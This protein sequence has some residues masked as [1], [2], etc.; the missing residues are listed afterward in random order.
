MSQ[1]PI[2]TRSFSIWMNMPSPYQADFFRA[3]AR[4]PEAN[5]HVIF[6]QPLDPMRKELGWVIDGAGFSSSSLP[7]TGRFL[8]ALRWAWRA[9]DHVHVING[10]WAVPEFLFATVILMLLGTPVYFHAE[11]PDSRGRRGGVRRFVRD[12]M[13]RM[14]LR[15]SQGIF[16]ISRLAENFYAGLAGSRQRV[17]PFGYFK[18]HVFRARPNGQSAGFELVFVGQLIERKAVDLLIDAFADMAN[19][20]P[21]ARLTLIGT[22]PDRAHL[23]QL[24]EKR[25]V[26]DRVSFAG[27]VSSAEIDDRIRKADVLVLP[28]HFDG[29]GLV[30][31]EALAGGVPVIVT[32]SCGAADLIR[33]R[34]DGYVVPPGD[35]QKL[36][37][38]LRTVCSERRTVRERPDPESWRRRIGLE[39]VT[40]YFFSCLCRTSPAVPAPSAPWLRD[41]IP[42]T[43][44]G[45]GLDW[46]GP[47]AHSGTKV[48]DEVGAAELRGSSSPLV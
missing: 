1:K 23:E 28:S 11:V 48:S 15:Q 16:A 33:D 39:A 7:A 40:D 13:G 14:L 26:S 21:D 20:A 4:R 41:A 43:A 27:S 37:N 18:H 10:I 6:G 19:D 31:N 3:L 9:R 5:L 46:T 24:A 22:G 45:G 34:R 36:A 35:R 29:W 2:E 42:E 32:S 8:A 44:I 47:A 30:I 17:L 12:F 38:A 25:F